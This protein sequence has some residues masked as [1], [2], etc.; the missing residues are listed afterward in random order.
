MLRVTHLTMDSI[1]ITS[2]VHPP[3]SCYYT[4]VPTTSL[5]TWLLAYSRDMSKDVFVLVPGDTTAI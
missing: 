1:I 3:T 2:P 4:I 5:Y